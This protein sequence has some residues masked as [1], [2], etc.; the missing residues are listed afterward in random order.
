MVGITGTNGRDRLVGTDEDDDIRGLGG[1]DDIFAGVGNDTIDAGG[2]DFVLVGDGDGDGDDVVRGS[3]GNDALTFVFD[4]DDGSDIVSDYQAGIDS[5][6][7]EG[8]TAFAIDDT[9]DGAVLVF[10]DTS[11]LFSGVDAADVTVEFADTL[12]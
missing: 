1:R 10:G 9:A 8:G 6:R 2:D 11:V 7:L 4:T 3:N 12:A 5:V